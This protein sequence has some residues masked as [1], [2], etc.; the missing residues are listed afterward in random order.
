[1]EELNERAK[2]ATS[3]YSARG[4]F[5]HYNYSVLVAKNHLRRSD[6]GV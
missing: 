6:Q 2:A 4:N 3:R 1:M 5:V